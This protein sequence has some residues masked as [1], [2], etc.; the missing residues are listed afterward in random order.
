MKGDYC[1]YPPRI[2]LDVEITGQH[3]G[4]RPA[5]T[6]GSPSAGR[7][8]LLRTVEYRVIKLLGEGL[9]PA[10]ICL[11]FGRRYGGTLPLPTLTRFLTR[12]DEIGILAGERVEDHYREQRLGTQFYRRFRL[13]NPD[14]FFARLV[15]MLRWVWTTQFF[16]ASL[17]LMS[18]AMLLALVNGA[19]IA[20]YG[21]YVLR[22]HYIGVG[23]A[24]LLVGITHEFAHG[25]TCKAFGG[26]ATE[27]GGLLIFYCLPALYCNVSGIHL[28]PQRRRRLWVIAAGVYW[29]LLVGTLALLAWF[30]AAPHTLPS[31]L[32]FVLFCGSVLDVAFN[33]NPLIKLDGYYFLSQ[34]LRLPNLMDRSRGWWRSLLLRVFFGRQNLEAAHYSKRQ[35]VIYAV[36]GLSSFVYA[37]VLMIAI[38]I[39]VGQYLMDWF[40]LGGVL[41]TVSLVLLYLRR[42]LGLLACA[43]RNAG[44]RFLSQVKGYARRHVRRSEVVMA[45]T[46]RV[47]T[48]EQ[49]PSETE[50]RPT[51]TEPRVNRGTVGEGGSRSAQT[52]WRRTLVP[53]A[54]CLLIVTVLLLPWN[55]S[56]GNSGTLVAIPGQEEIIRA[57]ESGRLLTLRVQPGE[58]VSFGAVI[59]QMGNLEIEEELVQ[60]RAELAGVN[61]EYSRAHGEL[62]WREETARRATWQV[63]QR[64]YDYDQV[65]AEQQQVWARGRATA[66][67]KE[68]EWIPAMLA[69]PWAPE[70]HNSTRLPAALAVLE[71]DMKLRRTNLAE[72]RSQLERARQLWAEGLLARRDLDVVETRAATLAMEVMASSERLEAA[73]IDHQRKHSA[74]AYELGMTNVDSNAERLQIEKLTGELAA[75][76]ALIGTLEQ[77][78]DLLQ[79][80]QAQFLLVTQRAGRVFGEDLQRMVGHYFPKGAEVCRIAGTA[81]L[82]ARIQVPE[83]E[84][85]DVR[86]GNPVRL[87]IRAYP[88]RVFTG[89]I[90][91]IGAEGELD[92]QQQMTYRIELVIENPDGLLRPGMGAFARIDFG[93]WRLGRILAHKIKQTLRPELWML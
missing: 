44:W 91:K 76:R 11:E 51:T 61:A 41:L 80:K 88:D 42:P 65:N 17:L 64:Q 68:I 31:D 73:L 7:Y 2:A 18:A 15:S 90:S 32:A 67:A 82:L 70:E 89:V 49:A 92:Q 52:R 47:V 75:I 77:R 9:T 56:V 22:E 25:L 50:R 14:P 74:A 4:D 29:Q 72:V 12:L 38:V 37:I 13:F 21:S 39:F 85:G 23:L 63:R 16:V 66:S 34:W 59:G 28:I 48:D 33:A 19:E 36:F 10:A 78:R 83:R 24:G 40:E 81:Q 45:S 93:R 3:G 54:A 6:I 86:A 79:R 1:D 58:D 53:S 46:E 60:V 62:R 26:R 43:T 55:A 71:S 8:L 5:F 20:Q 87:K 57:P 35:Q 69:A 84:I 27:V 30:M